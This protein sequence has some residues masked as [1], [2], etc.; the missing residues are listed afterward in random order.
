MSL[1]LDVKKKPAPPPPP[2]PNIPLMG[3]KAAMG[4][5][6]HFKERVK[7]GGLNWCHLICDGIK[8]A[9]FCLLE[10]DQR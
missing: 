3:R 2:A 10:T 5:R 4:G 8:Q 9:L 6:I 7:D 1:C